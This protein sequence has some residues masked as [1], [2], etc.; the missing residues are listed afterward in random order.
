MTTRST[1]KHE[2]MQA[3]H[4]AWLATNEELAALGF[5]WNDDEMEILH[6]LIVVWSEWLAQLRAEQTYEERDKA[7]AEAQK[8]LEIRRDEFGNSRES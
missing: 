7:L 8:V 6:A 1:E 5:S 3:E 4:G 2:L